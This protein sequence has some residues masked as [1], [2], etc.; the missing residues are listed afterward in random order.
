M[1]D[2]RGLRAEQLTRELERP[3]LSSVLLAGPLSPSARVCT[4][5]KPDLARSP[6]SPRPVRGARPSPTACRRF[7]RHLFPARAGLGSQRRSQA[8]GVSEAQSGR[9]GLFQLRAWRAGQWALG[10]DSAHWLPGLRLLPPPELCTLQTWGGGR[11]LHLTKKLPTE[12]R[13]GW[14][15]PSLHQGRQREAAHSLPPSLAHAFCLMSPSSQIFGNSNKEAPH[16]AGGGGVALSL[17]SLK[18][19]CESPA[20]P[21]ASTERLASRRAQIS[22]AAA[23][24]P[25]PSRPLNRTQP[26]PVWPAGALGLRGFGW[27]PAASTGLLPKPCPDPPALP[28]HSRH[29]R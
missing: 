17:P 7:P 24:P 23:S 2:G 25:G 9:T 12:T 29:R 22:R 13:G 28:A 6:D 1:A 4:R 21:H 27:L 8:A 16:L 15:C 20:W 26:S 11:C 18:S 14:V 5:A 10:H 19:G 3:A